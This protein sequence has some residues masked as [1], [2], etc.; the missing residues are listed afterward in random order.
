MKKIIASVIVLSAI[1]AAFTACTGND[2][3][4]SESSEGSSQSEQASE[5]TANDIG[6][7]AAG[8]VEWV[9]MLEITDAESAMTMFGLDTTLCDEYYLSVTMMSAHLNEIIIVKPKSGSEPEVE[10]QLEEHFDY[11]K[12][13]AAL[14]PEQEI[15]AAGAVQGKTADGYYYIIVHRIGSEI[16]DVIK[17]YQ[18]GDEIP[19]LEEPAADSGENG[20]AFLTGETNG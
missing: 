14:Y 19:K 4:S 20:G 6:S 12:N 17:D 5:R 1:L 9:S 16:A 13:S 11:V 15:S 7:A 8:C 10:T 2:S 18:P 3:G